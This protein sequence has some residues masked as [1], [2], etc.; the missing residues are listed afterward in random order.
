MTTETPDMHA[1]KAVDRVATDAGAAA[2]SRWR[3]AYW[4]TISDQETA[5]SAALQGFVVALLVAVITAVLSV[6]GAFGVK[7]FGFG[8][9][10]LVDAA[11]F[12]LV[13]VGIYRMSRVAALAG[14]SLYVVERVYAWATLGRKN[15]VVAVIFALAFVNSVRGTFA[16]RRFIDSRRADNLTGDT[17]ES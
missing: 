1:K 15:A 16:Y 13:A 10:S 12:A 4:P 11:V 7:L 3:R 17:S 14:L 5:R 6:L 8:P 9:S 2:G